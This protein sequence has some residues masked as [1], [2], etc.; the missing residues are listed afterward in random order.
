MV[1]KETVRVFFHMTVAF[2][3]VIAIKPPEDT[4]LFTI[5][6]R[7]PWAYF[8]DT[9]RLRSLLNGNFKN[10]HNLLHKHRDHIK[11]HWKNVQSVGLEG[12]HD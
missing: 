8:L 5:I 7:L 10:Q 11:I 6:K 12:T 9:S 1:R 4:S 3:K 2:A